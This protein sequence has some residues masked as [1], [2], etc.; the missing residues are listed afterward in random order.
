MKRSSSGRTFG[1]QLLADPSAARRWLRRLSL[2]GDGTLISCA[3]YLT[4]RLR[5]RALAELRGGR[6][7]RLVRVDGPQALDDLETAVLRLGDI[8]VHA[9]VVLAGNH[10][11]WTARPLGDPC[12]IKRSDDVLLAQR[13]GL[14]HGRRPELHPTVEA[15]AGAAAR[16]LL[17]A[18]IALV[19]RVEQRLAEGIADVLIEVEAAVEAFHM[20]RTQQ[21]EQVL[22]EIGADQLPTAVLKTGA[23]ELREEGHD[24]RRNDGVEHHF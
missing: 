3:P 11:R 7:H 13:A 17:S 15:G 24:P 21:A 20:R 18:G 16:K 6:H 8:H 10:F 12:V 14:G 4:G 1:A 22:V 9:D 2:T 23:M 5:Y 19:I